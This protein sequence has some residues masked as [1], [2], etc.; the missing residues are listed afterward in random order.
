MADKEIIPESLKQ[1]LTLPDSIS[2]RTSEV[3]PDSLKPKPGFGENVYRTLVG[4]ARDT[5]QATMELG[6]DIYEY[7]TGEEFTDEQKEWLPEVPEPQYFGGSV[8][9]DIT[10]FVIP[11]ASLSKVLSAAKVLPKAKT[12][13]GSATR[14]TVV[15]AAAEQAAFSPEEQ[16]LSN[17]VQSYPEIANPVTEYLQADPDDTT[18]QSRMKMALEGAALGTALDVVVAGARAFRSKKP[19]LKRETVG[20]II[21]RKT[22]ED[23]SVT[24]RTPDIEVNKPVD[25]VVKK[26]KV[27]FGETVD[28]TAAKEKAEEIAK[29]T[30]ED[31]VGLPKYA[32][33]FNINLR[34]ID[35]DKPVKAVLD[36]IVSSN[37]FRIE[38]AR[39]PRLNVD[40][41]LQKLSDTLG[42]S[43]DDFI[44]N[45][46]IDWKR[47][48]EYIYAARQLT[49][50]S[51]EDMYT[52]AVKA[53][54]TQSPA[55]YIEFQRS[56]E[57][58]NSL[59][60]QL[61]GL[62][63]SWGRGGQ[64]FKAMSDGQAFTPKQ[65]QAAANEFW[66]NAR[67]QDLQE[68]ARTIAETPR[69]EITARAMNKY[70]RSWPDV[71][72][73][74]KIQEVW[75]N[76]LLSNPVTH[77]VNITSNALVSVWTIPERFVAA[78]ISKITGKGRS[79]VT[80]REAVSKAFGTLE[81][82]GEGLRGATRALSNEDFI[83]PYTK[84]DGRRRAIQGAGGKAVRIPFRFLGAED[85]FF[86]GIGYRQ[87]LNALAMRQG[88]KENL[89]G[90]KLAARINEIKNEDLSALS[91]RR[92]QAI[93]EGQEELADQLSKKIDSIAAVRQAATDGARYQTFTN[94]AG[95]IADVFKGLVQKYPAARFIVPF[96]NT[97]AN[98]ITFAI[99]RTPAAPLLGKY[100]D[101]IRAGGAEADIA[102][103][104]LIMGTGVMSYVTYLGMQEIVTGRGPTDPAAYRVWRE[105]HQ[106]Y[107][108]RIGNRWYAY[109]R[110]EPLGV[111]FG[112]GADTAEIIRYAQRDDIKD[113][114]EKMTTLVSMGIA[115]FTDNI[116]NKTFLTG[117]SN[118]VDAIADPER[119]GGYFISRFGSS[120]VPRIVANV[121]NQMD[122]VRRDAQG[123]VDS[124]RN[125]IP[126]LSENLPPRRNIFGFV[127]VY[128]GALGPDFVSPFYSQT[129]TVD[130]VFDEMEKSE[131]RVSM[132]SRN[133]R[134]VKLTSAQY[135]ELLSY[136]R[137][138]GTYDKIS[139]VI[140]SPGYQNVNKFVRGEIVRRIISAD[141]EAARILFLRNN[142]DVMRES[143]T[144]RIEQITN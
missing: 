1:K 19:E 122:P 62:A 138:L 93:N 12:F 102:R 72:G 77:S 129:T 35:N 40:S 83:D 142:P 28:A 64:A 124:I 141:Q 110:V 2:T 34:N 139:N 131:I 15:G 45:R 66:E 55:D 17:L 128:S 115:S 65:R 4:A 126:T 78:G 71:R 114:D 63:A 29:K 92:I 97:P 107:S 61:T 21:D 133:L 125:S 42:L 113:Y 23:V 56:M 76:A 59:T 85:Q 111:L 5:A 95:P 136:M 36:D 121:R 38:A 137:Q 98:I 80:I 27:R 3:I 51:V 89:T 104:K 67:K 117:V 6:Y 84:L 46:N 54:R 8:V 49:V 130:P 100:R 31:E 13:V 134:G 10:G 81:G 90:R 70:V 118:L 7:A 11:Y 47:L 87:E 60:E 119:S 68:F 86:K 73:I 50:A 57:R 75:L 44:K 16:R 74:D 144:Q 22:P 96:I 79:G 143:V 14:A 101:A 105:N 112:L 123:I 37:S 127:Q 52:A 26:V 18:A 88:L 91:N 24:T 135:S 20:D 99:E 69:D 82:F 32:G 103:A 132:P 106:P 30:K 39:G 120:F 140:N 43:P 33:D 48:P 53:H 25:G 108:V 9:R 94:T 41:E 58:S 116:T 109:N